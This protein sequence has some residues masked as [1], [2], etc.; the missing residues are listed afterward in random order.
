MLYGLKPE[1]QKIHK[2]KLMKPLPGLKS[3]V[4]F[5]VTSKEFYVNREDYTAYC[6]GEQTAY[7]Q[8][9]LE[10]IE[11]YKKWFKQI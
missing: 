3:G 8:F 5:E 10:E 6:M 11:K 2:Y 7:Y 4:T 9:D 1:T